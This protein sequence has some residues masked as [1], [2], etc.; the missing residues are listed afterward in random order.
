MLLETFIY[1]SEKGRALED[2]LTLI[3]NNRASVVNLIT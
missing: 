2:F 1:Y 3:M